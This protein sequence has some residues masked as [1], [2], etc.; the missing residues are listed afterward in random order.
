MFNKKLLYYSLPLL[1][2][3]VAV[4]AFCET[5]A[6]RS[7]TGSGDMTPAWLYVIGINKYDHFEQLKTPV[8]DAEEVRD[9]L[10]KKFQFDE[11]HLIQRYNAEATRKNILSDLMTFAKKLTPD[12]MLLIYF[13]GHG[14][15]EEG[16]DGYWVPVDAERGIPSTYISNAEIRSLLAAS[17]ARHIWLISDACFSGAILGKPMRS[18]SPEIMDERFLRKAF[19]SRTRVVVASGGKEPIPDSSDV[20]DCQGH[21]VFGCY[22]IK[23]LEREN[24]PFVTSSEMSLELQR[25][26]SNTGLQDPIWGRL[27]ESG[28]EGGEFILVNLDALETKTVEK[29]VDGKNT[30]ASEMMAVHA[31]IEKERI[32]RKALIISG[33]SAVGLSAVGFGLGIYFG[34]SSK[35]IYDDLEH[36][37]IPPDKINAKVR[38]GQNYQTNE[39]ISLITGGALAVAGG[40]LLYF[41]YRMP[42][43]EFNKVTMSPVLDLSKGAI[44]LDGNF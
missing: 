38:E 29:Q 7:I 39:T 15:M 1:I 44:A 43:I 37:R 18:I 6:H 10:L 2:Q 26:V 3:L 20:K 35:S 31:S 40:L 36:G 22:F 42:S 32:K 5:T 4:D 13:A 33:Y 21:S 30:F 17:Q 25:M 24:E 9:V 28:D 11:A 27:R 19:K 34:L 8:H 14:E 12:D 16:V 41:G 23:Y